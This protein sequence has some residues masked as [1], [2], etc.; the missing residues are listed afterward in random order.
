MR[1]LPR[2]LAAVFAASLLF[3]SAPAAAQRS[4]VVRPGQSLSRIARQHRVGVWDLAHANRL[5]P[6]ATLR[7]G[8]TLTIPPQG[9]TFVRPGQTLSQIA[10]EHDT[11]VAELERL[12][13]LRGGLRAGT[14]LI[15][16]GYVAEAAYAG[17]RAW[18]APPEP[19]V[20]RIRRHREVV[21]VR[22]RD[23]EGRVTDEALRRLGELMRL[24]EDDAARIP[25]PRLAALL[26]A[27]S[28]H[29]GGREITLVSGRRP[30][31]GSTREASRHVTGRATDIR[32]EGVPRRELWDYCRTLALTGCGYYPR[33]TFVHVDVRAQA[34]QWV[35][36]AG[37]GGRARYGN[38]ARPWP[39]FCRNPRRRGQRA[40][41]REGRRVTAAAE[42]PVEPELTD[43][44]RALLP[45]LDTDEGVE[46][47]EDAEY[48]TAVD[49]EPE[50]ENTAVRLGA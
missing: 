24:R 49:D 35:D 3:A 42:V 7:P 10:R 5:E 8:Q 40:C 29:F 43:A 31:G 36:W 16:P 14:R 41:A 39:S 37:P 13:R 38:L 1:S 21:T 45:L 26:A 32:L 46:E 6:T 34:A 22:L 25:H 44:A 27:I 33:S 19:G 23:A 47:S 28:D 30:A 17:P 20:A 12:N 4:H 18:G 48:E 15:L 2:L 9:V 11:T 50:P